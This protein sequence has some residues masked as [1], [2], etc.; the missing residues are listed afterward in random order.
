MWTWSF[1]LKFFLRFSENDVT[2]QHISLIIFDGTM[3]NHKE[4]RTIKTIAS[5]IAHTVDKTRYK[6][7]CRAS[8]L[9]FLR[10]SSSFK[11]S[12]I[13]QRSSFIIWIYF[14]ESFLTLFFIYF[15]IFRLIIL[16]LIYNFSFIFLKE[17]LR[18]LNHQIL[19]LS[20]Y[21]LPFPHWN[22]LNQPESIS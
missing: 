14:F 9:V 2:I 19:Q 16:K 10:K 17:Q 21:L 20:E 3:C 7:A 5:T 18:W 22:K 4:V 8:F 1:M 12:L 6:K 13:H 15:H 11:T